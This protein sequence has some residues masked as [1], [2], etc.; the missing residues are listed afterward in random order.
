MNKHFLLAAM[1]NLFLTGT[2]ALTSCCG[3]C[4]QNDKAACKNIDSSE[5][6]L[7]AIQNR[8]SIRAYQETPVE[9]WKVEKILRAGMAA[10]SAINKQPW[11]FTVVSDK[12]L[13]Q[14]IADSA[15]NAHM[16]AQAP[17]AIVV[18]GD[19]T[20]AIEDP[21]IRE[22]WVQDCSA[23]TENILLAAH[24]LGLGAV[25][26][27]FYPNL[28]KAKMM[29][30]MLNMPSSQIVLCV[31]PMGYPAES[32]APKDKWNTENVHYNVWK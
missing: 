29:G 24:S 20:K 13:L 25:W 27:G 6:V 32:P 15:Q 9:D 3:T 17:L 11:S 7:Q 1:A 30:R 22:F 26:T 2:I 14:Q 8:T 23:A 4:G 10:P 21:M 31:I 19:M 16:A 5:V 28:E 12:A 18:S